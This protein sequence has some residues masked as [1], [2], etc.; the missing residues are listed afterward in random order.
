MLDTH[1]PGQGSN[2]SPSSGSGYGKETEQ[3]KEEGVVGRSD[4]LPVAT[5]NT[6]GVSRN[7]ALPSATDLTRM[8]RGWAAS[9]AGGQGQSGHAPE[10]QKDRLLD[11]LYLGE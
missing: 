7:G 11:T 3:Q 1:A 9:F 8:G 2:S 6:R 10:T 5:A 4:L